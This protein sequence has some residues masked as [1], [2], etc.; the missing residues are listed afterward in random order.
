M[1]QHATMITADADRGVAF[2]LSASFTLDRPAGE[3][4]KAVLRSTAHGVYE[5]RINRRVVSEAVLAPG[6]S[7][8]E[9]RRPA[10]SD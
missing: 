4:A 7:A 2:V 3:V 8:Y 1:L 9:W 5:V 6:W 10:R